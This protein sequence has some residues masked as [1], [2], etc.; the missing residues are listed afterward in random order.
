MMYLSLKAGR[1]VEVPEEETLADALMGSIGGYNTH[2]F[3]I[4]RNLVDDVVL[5]SEEEIF[6]AMGWLKREHGLTV[7]GGG[8]VGV[9][10]L[11]SGR[12]GNC[13]AKVVVVLS[14]GNVDP[15]VVD[16]AAASGGP[17]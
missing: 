4:V 16:R 2:T 1:P 8:A 11:R 3:D 5:V 15:A 12:V 9:A 13:G 7:E 14:G 6:S 17:R 10:A